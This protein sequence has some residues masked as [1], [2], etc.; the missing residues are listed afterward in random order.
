MDCSTVGRVIAV[1][2]PA[3]DTT[4]S[5]A[6]VSHGVVKA[7]W[8]DLTAVRVASTASR[9]CV[10]FETVAPPKVGSQLAIS[11]TNPHAVS[12]LE[13]FEPIIDYTGSPEPEVELFTNS[14]ISGEIGRSGHWVS[15]VVTSA[16]VAAPFAAFL[17]TAF[18]FHA[19]TQYEPR[20][21]PGQIVESV[22]DQAPA[23]GH[24][25]AYP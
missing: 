11:A 7:P 12:P 2:D 10:D 1:A 25:I 20:G 21:T 23:Q 5:Q 15:L 3:G 18:Q 24:D 17:R 9:F 22:G 8:V 6:G 13:S 14:P 4:Q 16:D 19:V